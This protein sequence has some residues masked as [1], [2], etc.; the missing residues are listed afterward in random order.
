MPAFPEFG[1]NVI[2]SEAVRVQSSPAVRLMLSVDDSAEKVRE[3]GVIER[4][5]L[6]IPASSS[7]FEQQ[8]IRT[9]SEIKMNNLFI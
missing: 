8:G 5:F 2:Q 6:S 3:T 1:V 9:R 7:G 4:K